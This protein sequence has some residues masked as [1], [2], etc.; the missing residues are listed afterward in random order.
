LCFC[1]FVFHYFHY[2]QTSEFIHTN[3]EGGA[4]CVTPAMH[5]ILVLGGYGVFGR[6]I[7][8]RLARDPRL[9]VVIAGRSE[10]KAKELRDVIQSSTPES[11]LS[12]FEI[13]ATSSDFASKLREL[14]PTAVVHTCGPYQQCDYSVARACIAAG[15]HYL[16]LADDRLFVTGIHTLDSEA[17]RAGVLVT[18]GCS[19][20]PSLSS[21]VIDHFLPRFAELTGVTTTVSPGNRCPRGLA[22]V[23]SILSY[24]GRPIP[25]FRHG[26]HGLVRGWGDTQLVQYPGIAGAR[27]V[28]ACDV[29]DM[30]LFPT[31]YPTVRLPLSVSLSLIRWAAA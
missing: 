29:P 10:S 15:A 25:A 28:A 19:T 7:C 9:E 31:R 13:D 24:C 18:S 26:V 11:H 2:F 27:I 8:A 23:R 12:T 21:A 6:S 4:S 3:C 14:S 30:A 17:R 20:V 1:R 5:R 16:D 22:T